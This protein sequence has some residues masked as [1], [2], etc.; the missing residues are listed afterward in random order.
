MVDAHSPFCLR[1]RL[2]ILTAL[3]GSLIISGCSPAISKKDFYGPLTADLR[4]N[5]YGAVVNKVETARDKYGQTNRLLYFLD[6]GL[7]YHYASQ[8]DSSNS[9]LS[10]AER[11]AEELFTKSVSRA[12]ASIVLNDNILEYSGEDY[13]ILYMNLIMALNY[14]SLGMFDDAFVE[15][16]RANEK[17]TLLEQKY[18]DMAHRFN[19]DTTGGGVQEHIN[20]EVKKVRFNND[21][22]A[23]YLSMHMYAADGKFDDARID[24]NLLT[25]AFATQPHIYDFSMPEV[26]YSSSEGAILSV[27]AMTGLAPS[28]ETVSLRIRTDKQL[29]IVQVMYDGTDTEVPGYGHLPMPVHKDYYFKFAVPTM[30]KRPSAISRVRVLANGRRVGELSLLE[31][32]SRVA[33]ETFEAKKSIIYLRSIARAIVKGLIAHKAKK[34]VDDGGLGGWLLKLG[35]DATLDISEQADLRCSHL[36]PGR[37]YIGDFDIEPGLYDLTIEFLNS[38]GIIVATRH[39]PGFAVV[40]GNFNLIETNSF[41]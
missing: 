14:I 31:D 37:I 41:N 6:S 24:K 3:L 21:A 12:A 13:E 27:V 35:V 16:R 9:R 40:K 26:I 18:A 33:I 30:K 23:R 29:N 7:A 8:Y 5:D 1:L 22:F 20:Y 10:V 11:S 39:V 15:I 25:E 4:R 28:K 38:D 2:P 19:Q 32:I 17:L 36:L 34:K